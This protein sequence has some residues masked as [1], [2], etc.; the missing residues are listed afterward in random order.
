LSS[1]AILKYGIKIEFNHDINPNIKNKNPIIAMGIIV[2]RG[3]KEL[4]F[5]V[6]MFFFI[7][8]FILFYAVHYLCF[9]F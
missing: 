6:V 4:P 2:S 5:T 7:F 1:H 3:L 9:Y 8:L